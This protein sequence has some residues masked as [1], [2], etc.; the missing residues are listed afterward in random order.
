MD[1]RNAAIG[2]HHEG[3]ASAAGSTGASKCIHSSRAGPNGDTPSTPT[4]T[5]GSRAASPKP[6]N[7]AKRLKRRN[8]SR[9]NRRR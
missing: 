9:L 6:L 8:V 2:F 7:R 1:I 5:N 4:R 3:D